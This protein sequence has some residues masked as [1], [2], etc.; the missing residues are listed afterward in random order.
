M[1]IRAC[2]WTNCPCIDAAAVIITA[3]DTFGDS[4]RLCPVRALPWCHLP[5]MVKHGISTATDSILPPGFK[6]L[7]SAFRLQWARESSDDVV[8]QNPLL[9]SYAVHRLILRMAIRACA[10]TNCPCIDAAA[11]I[12]TAVD[13]FGDSERLCPVRALPWC[14]LPIMVK[15]GISTATD[16]ILPPGFKGLASAFRLQWAR[17]SSDDVVAQNPLLLSYAG[18]APLLWTEC[19]VIRRW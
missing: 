2:A 11:V 3:L 15:H 13:T 18:S 1:A 16:S 8:A 5:I 10:W 12:I 19:P 4:E 6:G 9:L 7:A 14:H 17:E